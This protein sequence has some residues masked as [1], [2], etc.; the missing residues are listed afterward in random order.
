MRPPYD[1]E[2][3]SLIFFTMVTLNPI[4]IHMIHSK[5]CFTLLGFTYCNTLYSKRRVNAGGNVFAFHQQVL[6]AMHILS[7]N[8]RCF[9]SLSAAL[10]GKVG[11]IRAT[12]H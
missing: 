8:Q 6:F 7:G 5:G 4:L 9:A 3:L 10:K 12:V 1:M 2:I 11:P